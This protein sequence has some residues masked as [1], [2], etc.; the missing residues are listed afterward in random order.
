MPRNRIAGRPRCL[1]AQDG[2][3]G[4]NG[5]GKQGHHGQSHIDLHELHRPHQETGLSGGSELVVFARRPERRALGSAAAKA[6]QASAALASAS[7]ARPPYRA[8]PRLSSAFWMPGLCRGSAPSTRAAQVSSAG[9]RAA[10][11]RCATVRRSCRHAWY[12]TRAT[13]HSSAGP[14]ARPI[15]LPRR[16]APIRGSRRRPQWRSSA[17]RAVRHD[18]S[19]AHPP[20]AQGHRR[21]PSRSCSF[22]GRTSA[23]RW[24]EALPRRRLRRPVDAFDPRS[25]GSP[26]LFGFRHDRIVRIGRD[27]LDRNRAGK[28]GRNI[29]ET[30]HTVA[31]IVTITLSPGSW[32]AANP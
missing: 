29:G 16:P 8:A 31:V 7:A 21:L 6:R 26:A 5:S 27:A 28:S 23:G 14:L 2:D 11:F 18:G 25:T 1:L 12:W 32:S 3:G 15:G 24:A 19:A 10:W 22:P 4:D 20:K 13:R 17:S 30:P 9:R